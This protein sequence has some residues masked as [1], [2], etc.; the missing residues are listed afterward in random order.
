MTEPFPLP[1]LV[2]RVSQLQGLEAVQLQSLLAVTVTSVLPPEIEGDQ[3][4]GV[5]K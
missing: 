2:E 1:L 3:L 5:T 4:L